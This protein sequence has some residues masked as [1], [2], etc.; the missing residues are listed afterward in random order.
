[1]EPPE[2]E[3]VDSAPPLV[4]ITKGPQDKTKKKTAIFEFTG[5]DARAI[6]N[7]QCELD[8]AAFAPSTSPHTVKVKTGKYTFQV[9]AIDQAG[10]VGLPATDTWKRKKK[11]K[12]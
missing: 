6:A 9:E 7:F 11:R 5:T 2:P 8:A 3:T 4:A 12:S 10:N 1:V